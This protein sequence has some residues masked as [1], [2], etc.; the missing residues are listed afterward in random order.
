MLQA[1]SAFVASPGLTEDDGAVTPQVLEAVTLLRDRSGGRNRVVITQE[2]V[3]LVYD[4]HLIALQNGSALVIFTDRSLEVGLRNSLTLSRAR[5]KE[6]VSIS[7]DH[8]WEVDA[9]GAFSFIAPEGLLGYTPA[10]LIGQ[11]A[12]M[13]IDQERHFS[14]INPFLP[15]SP[16]TN[17]EAWVRTASGDPVCLEVSAVPLFN[18]DGAWLGARG[19]CRDVSEDRKRGAEMAEARARDR[20]LARITRLFQREAQPASMIKAATSAITHGLAATGCQIHSI[21]APLAKTIENPVFHPETAFGHVGEGQDSDDL[22]ERLRTQPLGTTLAAK[23]GQ[24]FVMVTLTAYGDRL[25]GALSVWREGDR[26]PFT[27]ADQRL[28][29]SIA[30]HVG[31]ALEQLY[32]HRALVE[33]SRTDGLTGLLNR[34]AF[35]EDVQRRIRRLE[36]GS[37]KAALMYVD[38]DNFKLVNDVRGHD[39]GDAALL[40]VGRMLRSNTRST[41]MVARLGGDEFAVWLDEADESVAINRAKVFL[42]ASVIL[43]SYSGA[44]DKPLMLSIGIALYDPAYKEDINAFISRADAAMYATKRKG[45]GSYSIAPLPTQGGA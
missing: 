36:R 38:L 22:R 19:V 30:G 17:T 32:N 12:A 37:G 28:L 4:L 7:S 16:L 9:Q 15:V 25:N 20:I 8:A 35:Y 42:A 3:R 6:L 5:Y 27:E 41:D 45:K 14:P 26:A 43:R 11:T 10:Q 18:T 29:R 34:R 40:D 1:N 39:V 31:V 23:R 24:R 33:V 2:K 13:L 44:A 21:A